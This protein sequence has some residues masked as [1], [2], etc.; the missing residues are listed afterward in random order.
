M[1]TPEPVR[2]TYSIRLESPYRL[3]LPP[4]RAP[5]DGWPL[6]VALHCKG[7]TGERLAE[8]F[9]MPEP[10]P[11]ARLFP[12]GPIPMILGEAGKDCRVGRS[13]Y[14]YTG[15]PDAL[16]E[17]LGRAEAILLECVDQVAARHGVDARRVVVLGHSQGG[18]LAS[19][20]A[21]RRRDRFA[22]LVA[23][24]CRIKHEVL[25]PELAA[26]AGYPVLGIHGERDL[27]VLPGPQKE[28]FEV[29]RRHRLDAALHLHHGGHGIRR[30]TLPIIDAFVRRVLGLV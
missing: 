24:S 20:A 4:G 10:L 5:A 21:L 6:L 13:W 11:Y 9:R 23:V 1:N 29:L 8:R 19:F 2:G 18:Y 25:G 16:L 3:E 30:S 17:E 15:D 26:A 27:S 7:D 12:S 14:N 22:G 28:A